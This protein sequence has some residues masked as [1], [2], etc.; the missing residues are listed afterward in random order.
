MSIFSW[1]KQP[2]NIESPFWD[3]CSQLMLDP[4]CTHLQKMESE[5]VKTMDKFWYALGV[6]MGWGL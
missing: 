4:F 5:D 6:V 1:I 3:E 2:L